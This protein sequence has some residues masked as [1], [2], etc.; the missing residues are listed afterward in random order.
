LAEIT[1]VLLKEFAIHISHLAHLRRFAERRST[2]KPQGSS[3]NVAN[4]RLLGI[5]WV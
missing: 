2:P 1:R 4:T 5:V 3:N